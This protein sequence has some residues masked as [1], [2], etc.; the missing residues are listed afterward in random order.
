MQV[1]GECGVQSISYNSC[2]NRHCP[3]CQ[4]TNKER[5]ILDRESELLPVPYYHTC[6]P[7]YRHYGMQAYGLYFAPLFQ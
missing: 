6:V 7:E 5:W 4:Q 2:R 3:K 1:C